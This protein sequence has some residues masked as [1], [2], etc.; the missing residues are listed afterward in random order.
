MNDGL[1]TFLMRLLFLYPLCLAGW[2]ALAGLQVETIAAGASG[3]LAALLSQLQF[4]PHAQWETVL[5][6]VQGVEGHGSVVIDPLVLTRGLPIFLALMLAAPGVERKRGAVVGGVLVIFGAA[7]VGF[8]G[9]AAVR[10]AEAVPG[11]SGSALVPAA[12]IQII[13]KSV[14]T[15]VLPVGLWLWQSW[16]FVSAFAKK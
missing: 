10:L 11:L 15:R 14:A 1:K 3:I 2:W 12:L 7:M 5:I 8:A 6:H 13:A 16:G 9:E 4:A